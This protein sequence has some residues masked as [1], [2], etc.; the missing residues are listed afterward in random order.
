MIEIQMTLLKRAL[1]WKIGFA[2]ARIEK[3]TDR[4]K[5]LQNHGGGV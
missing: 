3:L 5:N 2:D 1:Q 4:L